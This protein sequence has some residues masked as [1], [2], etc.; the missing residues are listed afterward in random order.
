MR[1]VE[2]GEGEEGRGVRKEGLK[3][4]EGSSKARTPS[5]QAKRSGGAE[6]EVW[7]LEMPSLV[8]SRHV[9]SSPS[10]RR[11]TRNSGKGPGP[12]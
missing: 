6:K 10:L 4:R 12:L 3:G 5:A 9:N 2:G 1:E 7:K 8:L 11:C